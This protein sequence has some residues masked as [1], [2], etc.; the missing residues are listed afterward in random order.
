MEKVEEEEDE[1]ENLWGDDDG[2]WIGLDNLEKKINTR[3]K[4]SEAKVED[5]KINVF[6]SSADFTL[7]NVA[8]KMGLPVLGID[9]KIIRRIKNYIFKCYSCNKFV[10]D[11]SRMFCDDCGYNTLM[12]IGYSIDYEGKVKVFD[13]DAEARLRGKQVITL[14]LFLIFRKKILIK[15]LV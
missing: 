3:L 10:F 5:L 6:I 14:F 9:G 15:T 12:K 13:K 1:D 2:E 7:Q 11:T 8:L 4:I